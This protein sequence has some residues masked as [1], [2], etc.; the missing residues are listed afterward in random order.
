[1]NKIF[2]AL[3]VIIL[4]TAL[5][6]DAGV[7]RIPVFPQP[8]NLPK[9]E[10]GP[11]HQAKRQAWWDLLH[12]AAP[13]DDWRQIEYHNQLSILQSQRRRVVLRDGNC[14]APSIADGAVAGQ[15]I[16][17]G[18][19]NQA[20]S[21]FDTEYDAVED[22]I[23]ILS[24]GGSLW[25][26]PRTGNEWEVV[27]ED[28]RFSPGLLKF[29]RNQ[30]SRRLLAFIERIPHFSDDD[31]I[32]WTAAKGIEYHDRFGNF[33]DPLVVRHG[34][35]TSIY[36]ISYSGAG[37]QIVLYKSVDKGENYLPVQELSAGQL[38]E[39]SLINPLFS[40]E[41]LLIQKEGDSASLL[42][43]SPDDDSIRESEVGFNFGEAVAN[44]RGWLQDTT[45][46]LFAYRTELVDGGRDIRV[47]L[48]HS[49]DRGGNWS[50][51]GMLFAEPWQVGLYISPSNPEVMYYGE[52]ECFQSQDAGRTWDRINSWQEYYLNVEGKLHA[53]IMN[54]AEF[55]TASGAPFLLVSSHG[56]LSV[57][58]DQFESQ[59][60]ISLENLNVS[61]YYSVKTD[62]NNSRNIY[63]GSQDQGLQ[64][65]I[66]GNRS[67]IL[68]F[69]QVLPGDFHHLVFT[70][71]FRS[72]WAVYIGG[73]VAYFENLQDFPFTTNSFQLDSEDERVWFPPIIASPHTDENAVLLAG[74]NV[75]GGPGSFIIRLE[76]KDRAI[77]S[78]QF[79][80][81]FKEASGGGVLSAL[82][83][84]P[85]NS[86][87]WYAATTNGHFFYSAD[88]GRTWSSNKSLPL[89][90][91]AF[92]GQAILPSPTDQ[93]TLY[94][95][96]SG[97]S[98]PPVYVSF[99]NGVTFTE[100]SEGLPSTLVLDLESHPEEDFLLAA[101][102][103]G[104]YIYIP[105]DDKW[106]NLNNGCA[107]NQAY[108][109]VEYLEKEEVAR[110]GTFGRGIW[111]FNLTRQIGTAIRAERTPLPVKVY[112][113][114]ATDNF[115]VEF[116]E[117]LLPKSHFDLEVYSMNGE[118]LLF[119]PGLVANGRINIDIGELPAG[120]Y[121]LQ[122]RAGTKTGYRKIVV[123]RH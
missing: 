25:K 111:D 75:D 38:H 14:N 100:M 18:S 112:P 1:M 42:E 59:T 86:D 72:I 3:F 66:D 11:G 94:L 60:N 77:I 87:L 88:A 55:R 119:K 12:Q 13:G 27:N 22:E 47:R 110:F 4:A 96:G 44:M 118:S 103:T 99:D 35:N 65:N 85:V 40:E 123:V 113:N 56:G 23:W 52:V 81:N 46:Q 5:S 92:Y 117:P 84:S 69:N 98:N 7:H 8:S 63:A 120:T 50:E 105:A 37:E 24:A 53:D 26:G 108:W 49:S 51:R 95:G 20:G 19:N 17:R 6:G 116:P 78:S 114:P 97:Y 90:T 93:Q 30:G 73:W 9:S 16:E 121:L 115:H 10:E 104:P 67:E 58:Y 64:I 101:T 21:V 106:Y 39:V 41:V 29:I 61:Q 91:L 80:F 62:P 45:L 36:V 122:V 102:E 71:D 109:S 57:T 70:N 48:Y 34:K 82:A 74:G 32:T 15:W 68:S 89:Q 33:K 83:I 54:F 43:I 31:G 76:S 28:L 107:P 79:D 2:N